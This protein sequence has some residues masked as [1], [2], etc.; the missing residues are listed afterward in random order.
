MTPTV[1]NPL[2]TQNSPNNLDNPP[3]VNNGKKR[4]AIRIVILCVGISIGVGL[5]SGLLNGNNSNDSQTQNNIQQNAN[6]S[7][8]ENTITSLHEATVA[9]QIS[10][11]HSLPLGDNKSTTAPRKGYVYVCRTQSDGN[12]GGAY[13]SGPW[14]STTNKT[15]DA[16]KKLTVNGSMLWS[17]A[18]WSIT[19]QGSSRIISGN[20]LPSHATGVYP[21]ASTDDA[22]Q[23]DRNPNTIKEQ[24]ISLSL[25]VDPIMV[26][27]AECI[28]GE[29]GIMLSGI[30]LFNSFDAGG[31]DAMAWEV[32]D[33]CGGHPQVS[34]LYH[35]HGP[36]KCS[37]DKSSTLQHADLIGYAF[38]GFG[39]FGS[40]GEQGKE[41]WTNDLD[42]CH[43]HI[44]EIAWDGMKKNMYHYHLTQDFPYSIS[45]F[46]G[47]K[48][49]QG[50]LGG[51]QGQMRREPP[52]DM[53]PPP[54]SIGQ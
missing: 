21:I 26:S 14:I 33:E 39:I 10:E 3:S 42:E 51:G 13:Q 2:D 52:Q 27:T 17:N 43:G 7:P 45:C 38:D 16:T 35:Y 9:V 49:I 28:G 36:S 47:K 30:P 24:T 29:V 8:K 5:I 41:L 34:G 32:Q 22:Y 46:R 12:M 19:K 20:G 18:K 15:W 37:V 40:K 53:R 31:R 48:S 11:L 23:Y 50:P 25:P 54:P 44:H 6:V 4:Y 1:T